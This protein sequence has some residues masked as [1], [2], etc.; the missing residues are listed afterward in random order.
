MATFNHL[1]ETFPDENCVLTNKDLLGEVRT[2]ERLCVNTGIRR[3]QVQSRNV[4]PVDPD[5]DH[6]AN[7]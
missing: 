1:C 5:S 4:D 3:L 6:R 7:T 2:S